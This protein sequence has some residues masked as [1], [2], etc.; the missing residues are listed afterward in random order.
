MFTPSSASYTEKAFRNSVPPEISLATR[1][2]LKERSDRSGWKPEA[3][4]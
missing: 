3:L 4:T 1:S 2:L